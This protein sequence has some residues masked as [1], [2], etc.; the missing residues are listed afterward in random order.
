MLQWARTTYGAADSTLLS[1]EEGRLKVKEP[2][3]YYIY[4][5]VTFCTK[6]ATLAPFTLSVYLYLPMEEDR[7]LLR[8]QDTHSTSNPQ[9]D[10]QSLRVGGAFR[11]RQG[12]MVFANVTDSLRM[13]YTHGNTYFGIFKL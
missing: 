8:G 3:L 7:L 4:S 11:L 5:Q 6:A 9:C 12:D 2:G 13:V 10:L 1:Y